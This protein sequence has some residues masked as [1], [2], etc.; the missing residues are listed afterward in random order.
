MTGAIAVGSLAYAGNAAAIGVEPGQG[1]VHL[2]LSHEET[3]LA[4]QIGVGAVLDQVVPNDQWWVITEEDSLYQGIDGFIDVTGAQLIE[5]AAAH[6]G[7]YVILTFADP[8][9]YTPLGV[10]QVW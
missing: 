3:L 2:Q 8:N 6:P 10:T 5:E 9:Q 1:Y 4:S 7:G